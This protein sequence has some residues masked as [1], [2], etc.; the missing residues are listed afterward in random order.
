MNLSSLE[1]KV[2][3]NIQLS[4]ICAVM[5]DNCK[6]GH[7]FCS[8]C[9][10]NIPLQEEGGDQESRMFP[11]DGKTDVITCSTLTQDFLIFATEVIRNVV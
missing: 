5:I 4:V 8:M 2:L 9:S 6:P 10:F 11:D 3:I 1:Q 7:I